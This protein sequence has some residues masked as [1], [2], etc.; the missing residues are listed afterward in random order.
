[1][2]RSMS[3]LGLLCLVPREPVAPDSLIPKARGSIFL[4]IRSTSQRYS[5]KVFMQGIMSAVVLP[6]YCLVDTTGA[7]DFGRI[8][9]DCVHTRCIPSGKVLMRMSDFM[10][11][12]Y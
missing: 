11:L 12:I 4:V 5:G 3:A 9:L 7:N 2:Q 10:P 1:M 8:R 6:L